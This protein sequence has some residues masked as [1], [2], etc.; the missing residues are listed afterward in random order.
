MSR[1]QDRIERMKAGRKTASGSASS[2]QDERSGQKKT[3]QQRLNAMKSTTPSKSE[4]PVR[5]ALTSAGPLGNT[6]QNAK[7]RLSGRGVSGV[8]GSFPVSDAGTAA[9]ERGVVSAITRQRDEAKADQLRAQA[10]LQALSAGGWS[11]D[12]PQARQAERETWNS[13]NASARQKV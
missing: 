12:S 2:N 10:R 4:K 5:A 13:L 9:Y 6:A 11:A 1:I 8:S 7:N 3:I